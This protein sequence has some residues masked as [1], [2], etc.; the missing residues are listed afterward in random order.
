MTGFI[1]FNN[2]I[3][4]DAHVKLHRLY[5]VVIRTFHIGYI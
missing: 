3:K 4:A 2:T 1:R 5:A